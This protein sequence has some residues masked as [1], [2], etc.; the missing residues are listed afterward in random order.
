MTSMHLYLVA[1][2]WIDDMYFRPQK[3][4]ATSKV[5]NRFHVELSSALLLEVPQP[6]PDGFAVF[7]ES[8]A[9]MRFPGE[10][11]SD[12]QEQNMLNYELTG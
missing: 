4:S 3:S 6:N 7:I 1:A 5:C 2:K 11:S 9:C 8:M 10:A 12:S